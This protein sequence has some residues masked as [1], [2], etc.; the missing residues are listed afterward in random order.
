[1][2]KGDWYVLVALVSLSMLAGVVDGLVY[3]GMVG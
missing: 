1:M 2:N 3:Y